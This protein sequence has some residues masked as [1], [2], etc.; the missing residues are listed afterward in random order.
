MATV[1]FFKAIS[2]DR[3]ELVKLRYTSLLFRLPKAMRQI[4]LTH[5]N[6]GLA[7][8]SDFYSSI[9]IRHLRFVMKML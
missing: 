1:R 7:L 3:I 6:M 2:I 8:T 4:I 5:Y 9:I